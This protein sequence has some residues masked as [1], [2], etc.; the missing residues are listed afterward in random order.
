MAKNDN[1]LSSGSMDNFPSQLS[2]KL[3][4]L[5]LFFKE[6]ISNLLHGARGQTVVATS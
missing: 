4:Q 1:S 5:H 6:K 3:V 2:N